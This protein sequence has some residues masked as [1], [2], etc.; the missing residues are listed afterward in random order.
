[1]CA[2]ASTR[3]EEGQVGRERE[4]ERVIR[5]RERKKERRERHRKMKEVGETSRMAGRVGS[6]SKVVK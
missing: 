1:M 2:G 4:R 3:G 5:E 6:G